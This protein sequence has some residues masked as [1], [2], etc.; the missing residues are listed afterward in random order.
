MWICDEDICSNNKTGLG[1]LLRV[2][3]VYWLSCFCVFKLEF[4]IFEKGFLYFHYSAFYLIHLDS[5]GELI[6]N[7]TEKQAAYPFVFGKYPLSNQHA[8]SS[9]ETCPESFSLP[10]SRTNGLRW[11]VTAMT[12][13]CQSMCHLWPSNVP[14]S[15]YNDMVIL[16]ESS[17]QQET[18]ASVLAC[19]EFVT[20]WALP[21]TI[22]KFILYCILE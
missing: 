11:S 22:Y 12:R 10:S 7:W 9:C 21:E 6:S 3:Y 15:D 18:V 13:N 2:I 16:L 14:G 8:K 4:L 17:L 1:R 19:H 20:C 5:E